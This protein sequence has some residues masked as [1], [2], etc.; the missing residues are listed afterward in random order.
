M[1]KIN[2]QSEANRLTSHDIEE[3]CKSSQINI[4]GSD[5][6]NLKFISGK[7][8]SETDSALVWEGVIIHIHSNL[9][10]PFN[11]IFNTKKKKNRIFQAFIMTLNESLSKFLGT[12]VFIIGKL[13]HL[14]H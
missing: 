2:F 7:R 8:L 4:T 11:L 12:K 6:H 3:I 13:Q 5:E 9:K 14:K 1:I 10:Y